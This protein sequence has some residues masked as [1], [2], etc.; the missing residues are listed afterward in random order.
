MSHRKPL[1]DSAQEIALDKLFLNALQKLR[2]FSNEDFQVMVTHYSENY[3]QKEL[4]EEFVLRSEYEEF[5]L[6]QETTVK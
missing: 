2:I 1:L 5:V 6:R 3:I 4:Y